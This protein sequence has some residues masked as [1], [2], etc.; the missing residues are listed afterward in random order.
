MDDDRSTEPARGVLRSSIAAGWVTAGHRRR[1][2]RA[3]MLDHV[4]TVR[5]RPGER[6]RIL[7]EPSCDSTLRLRLR[8]AGEASGELRAQISPSEIDLA[9][10]NMTAMLSHLRRGFRHDE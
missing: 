5:R 9:D 3:G 6:L 4:G 8:R 2:H 10:D 1:P 7:T